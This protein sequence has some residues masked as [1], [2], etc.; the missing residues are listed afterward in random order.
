[1]RVL[2]R[3][4]Q[5]LERRPGGWEGPV[6]GRAGPGAPATLRASGTRTRL[7]CVPPAPPAACAGPA[8]GPH[9]SGSQQEPH[10]RSRAVQREH[11]ERGAPT[12]CNRWRTDQA[13]APLRAAARSRCSRVNPGRPFCSG[14]TLDLRPR[15]IQHVQRGRLRR[16]RLRH[17]HDH[18]RV[19]HQL[20]HPLETQLDHPRQRHPA[21]IR[22]STADMVRRVSS[23]ADAHCPCRRSVR[24]H[25]EIVAVRRVAMRTGPV[26]PTRPDACQHSASAAPVTRRMWKRTEQHR[27]QQHADRDRHEYR[28]YRAKGRDVRFRRRSAIRGSEHRLQERAHALLYR[29]LPGGRDAATQNSN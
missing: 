21:R 25:G 12:V 17:D 1:M 10:P 18:R 13:E 9:A 8:E 2:D 19:R 20:A 16:P 28:G 26:P 15:T 4:G 14:I 7:R 3:L 22:R 23:V 24:E 5:R 6:A 29:S 11:R 27:Q